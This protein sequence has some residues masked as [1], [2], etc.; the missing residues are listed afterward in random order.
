MKR[1][2]RAVLCFVAAISFAELSASGQGKLVDKLPP[3]SQ[4]CTPGTFK[5]TANEVLEC[6]AIPNAKA[7]PDAEIKFRSI[8]SCPFGCVP[9]A[10]NTDK[11]TCKKKS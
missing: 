9:G 7:G 10:K 3:Q 8:T 11:P 6:K 4:S 5:C 1:S 2:L